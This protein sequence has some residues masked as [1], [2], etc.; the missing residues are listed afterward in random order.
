MAEIV[1]CNGFLE[2]AT[3]LDKAIKSKLLKAMWLLSENFRHPSL[4][5]KKIQ[6]A[7]ADVFECRVDQDTRLIYDCIGTRIR[8]WYVGS[9]DIAIKFGMKLHVNEPTPLIPSTRV[10]DFQIKTIPS[11]LTSLVGY[12]RSGNCEEP[13]SE[14]TIDDLQLRLTDKPTS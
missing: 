7:R 2:T 3:A 13:F 10:D 6:G 9:H 4:Q 5:C 8:C 11:E 1:M 14:S 12:L